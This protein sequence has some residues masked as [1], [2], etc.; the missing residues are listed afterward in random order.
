M[1]DELDTLLVSRYPEIFKN[2]NGDMTTTAMCWGFECG[3]GWFDIINNLCFG[4]SEPLRR[5]IRE[6]ESAEKFLG[7]SEMWTQERL[8]K[9]RQN[10]E[11]VRASIPVAA[12]VKEK[13]GTLRFYI[14][15][16]NDTAHALVDFAEAMS[17][18]TCEHC[19]NKG[20][21]YP[22]GWVRTLCREHA[23]AQYGLDK[24]TEYEQKMKE[25]DTK[26]L[27]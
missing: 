9:A 11:I 22:L 25:K 2:R 13:F 21:L 14:D 3:D 1:R 27:D 19:G 12:Q 17:E 24:V 15:N 7:K 4:L 20:T 8:D 6:L 26:A 23:V 10:I 16:G 18:T 5:A